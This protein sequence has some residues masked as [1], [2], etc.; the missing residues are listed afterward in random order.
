MIMPRILVTN[1]DGYFSE[2][3]STLITALGIVGD[4]TVVAPASE[5]SG[6]AHSVTTT[7]P[8]HV[9]KIAERRY[10]VDGT[11][12]DCVILA[13]TK[14]L[15]ERPEAVVSGINRGANLGDYAIYSGTVAAVL[16]AAL[17]KIPGVAVNLA[18]SHGDFTQAARFAAD[19][20]RQV[21]KE[22]LPE[23]SILNVNI[24]LG[25][26][27]GAR[28]TH[29]GTRIA[30]FHIAED[31]DPWGRNYCWIGEREA[32]EKRDPDS[33]YEAVADGMVS[34]TPLQPYMTDHRALEA[35][36]NGLSL[37]AKQR[38]A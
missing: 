11:P 24:P 25:A 16:E 5:Q 37:D 19:L 20:T 28:F 1:D 36:Q 23:G 17:F 30:D 38:Y 26:I 14:I 31:I 34:I 10:T 22:G 12:V 33:D 7:R 4:V 13:L 15:P 32:S 8:L 27:R 18:A 6:A 3:L 2:G 35:L 21:L 29:Q 9:R